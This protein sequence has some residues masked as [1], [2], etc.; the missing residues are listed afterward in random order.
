[1]VALG[2]SLTAASVS[3]LHCLEFLTLIELGLVQNKEPSLFSVVLKR[4]TVL[5][6]FTDLQITHH[7]C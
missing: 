5:V 1:M 4:V 2:I 7:I 6:V 3:F